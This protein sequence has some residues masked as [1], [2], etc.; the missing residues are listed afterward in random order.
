MAYHLIFNIVAGGLRHTL[1]SRKAMIM[2][3]TNLLDYVLLVV[4]LS[5]LII[6]VEFKR[7]DLLSNKIKN[8]RLF[9][10]PFFSFK[11]YSFGL[12][13]CQKEKKTKPAS[14]YLFI[15]LFI[16]PVGQLLLLL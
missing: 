9:V 16:I 6:L 7:K 11:P 4:H 8:F 5:S 15:Y 14:F 12:K 13:G 3:I 2:I 1:S 10:S